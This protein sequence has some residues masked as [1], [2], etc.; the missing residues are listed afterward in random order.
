MCGHL[1]PWPNTAQPP[2]TTTTTIVWKEEEER[3]AAEGRAR[4]A[5]KPWHEELGFQT[6]AAQEEWEPGALP[7][8]SAQLLAPLRARHS[9]R[10]ADRDAFL[11]WDRQEDAEI[12]VLHASDL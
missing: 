11:E 5:E 7:G 4:E 9:R 8:L 2:T 10:A 3:L 12:A 1:L 6:L